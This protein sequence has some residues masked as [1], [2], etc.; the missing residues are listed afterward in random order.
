[1]R[2][3]S[4]DELPQ[5]RSFDQVKGYSRG[6]IGTTLSIRERSGPRSSSKSRAKTSPSATTCGTPAAAPGTRRPFPTADRIR[7]ARST[8]QGAAAQGKANRAALDVNDR[9]PL[10]PLDESPAEPSPATPPRRERRAGGVAAAAA[11]GPRRSAASAHRGSCGIP[12]QGRA[13]RVPRSVASPLP[14]DVPQVRRLRAPQP[15][16]KEA[17]SEEARRQS[18]PTN[19]NHTSA[20][21]SQRPAFR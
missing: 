3:T 8:Y 13:A 20:A 4:L 6:P 1:L 14:Q 7:A 2:R 10:L 18:S 21:Q 5:L 12:R 19:E 17:Q 9:H 16:D 11:T 15:T